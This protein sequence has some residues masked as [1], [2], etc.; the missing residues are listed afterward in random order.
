MTS[1]PHAMETALARNLLSS[2]LALALPSDLERDDAALSTFLAQQRALRE[3]L[4]RHNV[5]GLVTDGKA[6][7]KWDARLLQLAEGSAQARRVGWELLLTT[8]RQSPLARLEALA[9]K[10]LERVVKLL[11]QLQASKT[12]DDDAE[13]AAASACGV[14]MSLLRHVD[15]YSPDARREALEL[16][17]KLLQPLVALLSR[18]SSAVLM[19]AQLELVVSLM[20]SSPN[21]LRSFA[22]KIESA[23]VGALFPT[24]DGSEDEELVAQKAVD[25]LALLCNASDKPQHVWTQMAQKALEAAH[26]QLDLLA[27][28]RAVVPSTE[29]VTGMKLWV[30]GAASAQLPIYQRA[31]VTLVRMTRALSALHELL[32]ARTATQS[33]GQI[34]ERE[35]QQVLPE[36]VTFARRALGVRAHEVGKHTGVSDDGVRLPISVVYA[37]LPRVHAQ[38]L[39]ALSAAVE[40]TGICALRHASKITRVLLLASESV[41]D[42]ED[43]QALADTTA[44]CA[45]R[46][47]ASTV[48]KLGVP[49]LNELVS[50]CKRSLD[51]KT[52]TASTSNSVAKAL[53][54][55][56]NDVKNGGGKSKKRKRQA[57]AAATL[58]ALN[59]GNAA[60]G[61]ASFVSLRDESVVALTL[62]AV[63]TAIAGCVSV[64][65]SLLPDETRSSASEIALKAVQRRH[66][67]GTGNVGAI[68]P[69][70]LALLSGAVTADASGSHA[71]NLL[72]GLQYWQRRVIGSGGASSALQLVALNAGEAMLHPRAP[73]MAINFKQNPNKE[74][75]TYR[76]GNAS[77]AASK[78]SAVLGDAMDWDENDRDESDEE[79]AKPEQEEKESKGE[80]KEA[81]AV[82]EEEEEEED[83]E[84][85]YDDARPQ[86]TTETPA[87]VKMDETEENDDDEDEDDD[88]EP[89]TKR[90]KDSDDEKKAPVATVEADDDDD[91]DFPDIVVDDE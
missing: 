46:L 34:S 41:G 72:H 14:A 73:P 23:C 69:V 43:L 63:L 9:S 48:E 57:A 85:D 26:Q 71:A 67:V 36:V 25:C 13:L 60:A 5:F 33:R 40:R 62:E 18:K 68:D 19:R 32:S 81:P 82:T 8:A 88:D 38:A 4:E 59:G 52:T 86:A 17:A 12:Q 24:A 28:K 90:V 31:E 55:Q 87:E 61:H 2:V 89:A 20:R 37:V 44:V 79:D 53:A 83:E 66:V 27:G 80:K 84:E 29:G 30:Q 78:E 15:S 74:Q 16:L 77:R 39:R 49:L 56:Q 22:V 1:D 50:R 6:L 76:F 54:A 35:A 42:G 65:G 45:R 91:D 3:A 10:L 47:G 75:E 11:K 58:A 70:A 64:Y 21:S 51:E 7:V